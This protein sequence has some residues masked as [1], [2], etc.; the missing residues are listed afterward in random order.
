MPVTP[1][2][3]RPPRNRWLASRWVRRYFGFSRAE[4]RGFV[5]LLLGA[6]AIAVLP[7]L[8]RP[9]DPEYLPAADQRQLD[10]WGRDLAARL[11]SGR[12]ASARAYAGRYPARGS[13]EA[14]RYPTVPQVPLAPFDP[15]ILTAEGWEA[16]GVPHFV[17]GRI[18]NYGQ[19]A[20]GFRAKSQV[21]RIYGLPDSVYQRLAPFMQLP[22][23]LPGRGDKYAAADRPAFGEKEPV[24]GRFPRKPAHL[25]PF[26]LNL[27]DT[28]QLMQIKGIGR[29]RAKWIV[30]HRDELGGYLAENQLEEVFVLRD[31]PDLVDSLRKYTF[32]AKSFA[33]RPV[34]VNSASFDELWPHPYVGKPLA[35]LIVA[36]RKQHG[37]FA[38]PDDLRQLKLL[39]EENFVKLR[40]YVRCE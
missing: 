14:S 26:D 23:A 12:A 5:L 36:Y 39:K 30:K 22:E 28:T 8:L 13:R 21:Q 40:P 15:N 27:A 18:V 11:D 24:P 17:A 20:G 9:T 32:V 29:G 37:P 19:K 10:A 35:R 34:L 38:A 16:R 1:P 3:P 7:V 4:T 33:P 31:A 2:P 6:L 25:Q